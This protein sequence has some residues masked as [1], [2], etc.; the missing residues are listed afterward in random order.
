M[1]E[2]REDGE[3]ESARQKEVSAGGRRKRRGRLKNKE[4]VGKTSQT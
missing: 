1:Y 2:E 3:G 4:L